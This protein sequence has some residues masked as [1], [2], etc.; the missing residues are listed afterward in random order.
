MDYDPTLYS[1]SAA[2]Y[3]AGRPPYS[4]LLLSV[5]RAELG[6]DGSGSLLDVGCGPGV[7]AVQLAPGFSHVSALDPDR[8]MLEAARRY[9][10]DRGI[11]SITWINGVA[12]DLGD[13]SLDT[14]QV[15]TFG[16]SFHW[17][18]RHRVAEV[19]YDLLDPGGAVVMV[20]H[21]PEHGSP[22][23][24]D[25]PPIPDDE[26][27]ALIHHYLGDEPRRGQG[28]HSHTHERY[29]E[30]L[31][32]TRFETSRI[33]YAPGAT[34]VTRDVGG[35][36]SNYLSM[37]WAA[38]HLFGERL[39]EFVA[40]LRRLLTTSTTTGRFSQWPGDTEILIATKS[41]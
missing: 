19:I 17:T 23:V 38:P 3:L 12:E 2:H 22:P 7:L 4:P 13:L 6:L 28:F 27:M 20:T 41:Q 18:N 33:I 29:G 10:A 32:R 26:V 34:D 1:G 30:T 8:E 40:E 21:E 9:A 15:A 25:D 11:T 5:L 37:S 31:A 35:V 36:I 24:P 16:Q 14:I 39:N